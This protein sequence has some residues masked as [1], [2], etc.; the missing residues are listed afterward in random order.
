MK[1]VK[2]IILASLILFSEILN[3]QEDISNVRQ[4][5]RIVVGTGFGID[6]GGIGLNLTAYPSENFA[7][8][9]SGGYALAGLGVNAGVK[10]LFFPK[11]P[12]PTMVPYLTAM[13]GYNTAIVVSN[14]SEMNK[15]FYGPTFG[16]GVDVRPRP[17]RLVYLSCAVLVPLRGEKVDNYINNNNIDLKSELMPFGF[18]FGF[19]FILK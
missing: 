2:L 12:N 7:F 1:I 11:R 15:I 8:F 6:Y 13:Y 9:V 19:K 4:Y 3:A 14:D 16:V 17:W 18:S 10:T 5:D